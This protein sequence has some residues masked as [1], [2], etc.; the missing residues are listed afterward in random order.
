MGKSGNSDRFCFLGL[1][2]TVIVAD[3]FS[4][5][6]SQAL[7]HTAQLLW[8][9][10]LDAPSMWDLNQVRY[11]L[12]S[13]AWAGEFFTT[14]SPGKLKPGWFL[15]TLSFDNQCPKLLS[16]FMLKH[17][18]D[19]KY[20]IISILNNYW[21]LGKLFS[22]NNK[23]SWKVT[24]KIEL[25]YGTIKQFLYC[26]NT[27]L[28][29]KVEKRNLRYCPRACFILTLSKVIINCF[30]VVLES[31]RSPNNL[32]VDLQLYITLSVSL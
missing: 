12:M 26:S 4:S 30:T 22:Q 28:E 5:H 10:G 8:C 17:L 16:Y 23:D 14:E 7:G 2:I 11:Q 32:S 29:Q 9:K 19:S 6:G 3:G 13:P 1:Q 21:I 31:I 18:Y 15:S 25:Y 27:V 20:S 24:L